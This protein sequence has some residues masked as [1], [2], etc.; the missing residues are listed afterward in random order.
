ME[1]K[2]LPGLLKE[3]NAAR[4]PEVTH[5]FCHAPYLSL[6]FHQSGNVNVCCYNRNHV[7]GRYP[8]NTIEEMWVGAKLKE[9]RRALEKPDLSLGCQ[10]CGLVLQEKAFISMHAR[11]Y[12]HKMP[13]SGKLELDA[14]TH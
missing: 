4:R 13:K 12:D 10:G 5:K 11:D 7:L 2:N 8:E 3:Y 1:I 9:L 6:N 14:P